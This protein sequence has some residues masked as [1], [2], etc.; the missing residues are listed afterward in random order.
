MPQDFFN[1]KLMNQNLEWKNKIILFLE[2]LGLKFIYY[3][4][5]DRKYK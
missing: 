4:L 1:G 2:R 3:Y 5:K